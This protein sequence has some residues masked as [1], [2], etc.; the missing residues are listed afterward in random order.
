MIA[1][2]L[3]RGGAFKYLLLHV[4]AHAHPAVEG[5][6]R[7][8]HAPVRFHAMRHLTYQSID[9]DFLP[10]GHDLL[11]VEVTRP[12]GKEESSLHSRTDQWHQ[13]V[14]LYNVQVTVVDL[15][16][17]FHRV[18]KSYLHGSQVDDHEAPVIVVEVAR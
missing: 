17:V 12:L 16:L 3:Q 13:E 9:E 6:V 11:K 15:L 18:D 1:W 5:V 2:S 8:L 14:F 4:H 10:G 7:W